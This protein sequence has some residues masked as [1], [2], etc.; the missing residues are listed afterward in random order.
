MQYRNSVTHRLFTDSKG[1]AVHSMDMVKWCPHDAASSFGG[2]IYNMHPNL[3]LIDE[4]VFGTDD[5]RDPLGPRYY[6]FDS[7]QNIPEIAYP[8]EME[9][10]NLDR[11][12]PCDKAWVKEFKH[13]I[14][15]P[16]A[17]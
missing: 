13:L 16:L 15:W 7:I 4:M 14:N 6:V 1:N 2:G 10:I 5:P 17:N 12:E 11:L 8:Y 3:C 9:K